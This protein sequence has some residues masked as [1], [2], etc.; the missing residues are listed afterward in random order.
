METEVTYLPE[1][2]TI[3]NTY[4]A[5]GVVTLEVTKALS[6]AG[7]P[8]GKSLTLTIEGADGAPAPETKTYKLTAA[9]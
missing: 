4:D 1:S 2:G 9:G 3:T 6:G 7:W 5:E 8:E